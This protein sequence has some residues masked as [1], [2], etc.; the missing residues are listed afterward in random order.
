MSL[1]AGFV[2]RSEGG[3][4]GT[5]YASQSTRR[6]VLEA[7]LVVEVGAGDGMQPSSIV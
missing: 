1:T 4:G 7:V 2:P 3:E 5:Q 6:G